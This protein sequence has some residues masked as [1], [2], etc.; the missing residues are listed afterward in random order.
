AIYRLFQRFQP[1]AAF[2]G[3]AAAFARKLVDQA[4]THHGA[5]ITAAEVYPQFQAQAG[6]PDF[7]LRD[8]IPLPHAE[9][10]AHFEQAVLGQPVAARHA[11]AVVTTL[12]TGLN[13][14]ERPLG[15]LLFCGPTGVG[16][17]EMAKA[18][19]RYLFGAGQIKDRLV[20]LDMSE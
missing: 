14:P 4:S 16:K 7:L 1:Y 3:P 12:K 18:L 6:L 8:E 15:V 9:V 10:L 13:D 5:Q 17:T 2:P 20:R 11:A 19:A